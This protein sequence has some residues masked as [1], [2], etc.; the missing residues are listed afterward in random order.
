MSKIK[1]AIAKILEKEGWINKVE[2]IKSEVKKNHSASFDQ[3][4]IVLKY[5]SDGRPAITSLRRL[6][7]PGLRIYVGKE[8]LPRVLNNLGIAIVSTP[9]GLMTNK[10]AKRK[11]LGGELICEIY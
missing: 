10:E 9:Q 2:T 8:E 6:S 3:L 11:G 4:K 1:F 5:R 7:K